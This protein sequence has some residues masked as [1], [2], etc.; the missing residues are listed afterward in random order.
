MNQSATTLSRIYD[1]AVVNRTWY[2]APSAREGFKGEHNL[3]MQRG[4]PLSFDRQSPT[5]NRI[6]SPG[7][8]Y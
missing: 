8:K 7:R 2:S 1:D 3:M 5:Y 6:F 4:G